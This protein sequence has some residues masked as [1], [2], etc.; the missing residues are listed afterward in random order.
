MKAGMQLPIT[1]GHEIVGIIQQIGSGVQ[2]KRSLLPLPFS[3]P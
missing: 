3:P 2:G 1:P